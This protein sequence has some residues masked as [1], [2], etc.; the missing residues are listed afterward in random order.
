MVQRFRIEAFSRSLQDVM[1]NNKP[2][3]GKCIVLGGDFQQILPVLQ[4]ES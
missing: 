3:G 1:Q 2:F 4:K